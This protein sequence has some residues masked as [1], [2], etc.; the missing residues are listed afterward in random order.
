MSTVKT[1]YSYNPDTKKHEVQ[2]THCNTGKI[3]IEKYSKD[4]KRLTNKMI[5]KKSKELVIPKDILNIS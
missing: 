4:G 2:R 5:P 1:V 3:T